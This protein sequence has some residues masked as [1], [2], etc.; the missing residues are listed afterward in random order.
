[1]TINVSHYNS[2]TVNISIK[3]RCS[4]RNHKLLTAELVARKFL[5]NIYLIEP[6]TFITKRDF[7]YCTQSLYRIIS[8]TFSESCFLGESLFDF[9]LIYFQ[10][11]LGVIV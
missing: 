10:N 8:D 3:Q 5:M 1:M 4:K 7:D 2:V 11:A 6:W 9:Y